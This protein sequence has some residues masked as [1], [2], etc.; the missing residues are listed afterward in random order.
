[1]ATAPQAT[2]SIEPRSIVEEMQ[3]SYLTYAMSVITARALPD[4][5]DGL[6]PS[7]RR[8]LV[9]MNDLNLG[10]RSQHRKCAKIA[11][12][13]SGNYHPHG[14]QVIYP[15]LVRLAQGWNMRI[16]LING[17]GNFGSIDGDP[18]AAMRYTEARLQAVA[19]EML[20]DLEYDTV[21]FEPNYDGTRT[22]PVVL[23]GKF[24]NLL[25]NGGSGIAVGMA[26]NL[27]PHNLREICDAIILV[28]DN[29]ECTLADLLAVVPGPDFPTGGQICGRQGIVDAYRTGRGSI[30][31]RG[32]AGVEESKAGKKMVVITEVPYQVLR[33]TITERIATAVRA[34][35]IKDVAAINDA[36]DRK[37]PVRIEVDLKRDAN[38]D[39]VLNQLYRYTPLQTTM[40]VMNTVLVGGQPKAL[41]LK[42]MIELYI[43]HRREVIRRRTT[44]LLRRAR[45]RAHILEA[46]IL[47]VGDIDRI[48]EVIRASADPKAAKTRLMA[49]ELRLAESA[50]LRKLLPEAFIERFTAQAHHLTP[51]QAGA[52]LAM[53]LQ[54]LTGLE[55]EN[56][57]D[58]RSAALSPMAEE[59]VHDVGDA[60]ITG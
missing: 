49:I 16:P 19:T 17:Q 5:R 55:I 24:P 53:Q 12:D 10:P 48:I 52:I 28:I 50:T 20:S 34:G 60:C 54:R 18:P 9:A 3:D 56:L 13:T 15:T 27:A 44:F 22:E 57:V 39:V 42:A 43:G 37:N 41:S 46:L 6:K 7:Q 23:P 36:S 33:N 47:A 25:V 29:P 51:V 2:E 31:I 30:T 14:E 8:I 26:T 59:S 4:G 40:T 1:M 35:T 38:E 58:G 32:K 11:G 45:Q 21:D